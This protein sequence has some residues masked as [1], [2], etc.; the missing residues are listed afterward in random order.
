[1]N[2]KIKNKNYTEKIHIKIICKKLYA[3]NY[4]QKIAL[5]IALKIKRKK[6]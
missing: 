1:M 4:M 2:T 6:I 3:K 5:K